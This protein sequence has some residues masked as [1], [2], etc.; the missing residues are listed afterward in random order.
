MSVR[1]KIQTLKPK[2]S[3]LIW[4]LL[5]NARLFQQIFVNACTTATQGSLT[6]ST[7]CHKDDRQ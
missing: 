7:C 6:T 3:P 1:L 4:S 2:T 5:H